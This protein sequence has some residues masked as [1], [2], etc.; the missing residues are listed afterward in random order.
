M[1]EITPR[2]VGRV[3][4]LI[5]VPLRADVELPSGEELAA[6]EVE[7]VPGRKGGRSRSWADPLWRLESEAPRVEAIDDHPAFEG[8]S[9]GR[10]RPVVRIVAS[11]PIDTYAWRLWQDGEPIEAETKATAGIGPDGLHAELRPSRRLRRSGRAGRPRR[12]GVFYPPF[13]SHLPDMLRSD[14]SRIAYTA[15]THAGHADQD[16]FAVDFNWHTGEADR[17][18]WVRAA[19]A[20][21]VSHVDPDNGQVH[22]R[23]PGFDGEHDWET[24]Y[25][26]LDPILVREGQR[27]R[28]YRRI[29]RIGSTYHGDEVISPHLHHQ[30]RRDGQPVRMRLLVEGRPMAI[31]VSRSDPARTIAGK[32]PVPGW[33][34][35]RGPAPA[36]LAVRTRRAADGHWSPWTEM[37]FILAAKDAPA[38]GEHDASFGSD[39]EGAAVALEYA[40]PSVEPGEYTVRYRAHGDAGT[41]TPWAYDHTIA[42]E[43]V[44]A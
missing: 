28:A 5:G 34:R 37:G 1:A 18:H 13:D 40:G 42:V 17:G 36:R 29:G 3:E 20:G 21:V 41:V 9:V 15:L 26:H 43:P 19:A 44:L 2:P 30:H 14:E 32:S 10:R 35:P 27:V 11:E 16:A 38:I 22:I 33:Q 25:A 4:Q 6:Y 23:H 8:M 24:V 31:G 12:K 39:A 7:L